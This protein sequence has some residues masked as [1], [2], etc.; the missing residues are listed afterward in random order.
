MTVQP[1]YTKYVIDEQKADYDYIKGKFTDDEIKEVFKILDI[2]KSNHITADN[3]SYFLEY[4]GE[5]ATDEE[6][7]EM[8]KM[9]DLD[10]NGEVSYDE[11]YKLASGQSLAPIGQAYTPTPEMQVKKAQIAN[12]RILEQLI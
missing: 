8:I 10:G 9:C 11:F 12:E 7:E 2:N 5:K 4:L 3:L 6:I 1:G